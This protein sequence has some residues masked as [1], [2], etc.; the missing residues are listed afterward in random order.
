MNIGVS[1]S[2][3][4]RSG[5]IWGRRKESGPDC[6]AKKLEDH[7]KGGH[8]NG[9]GAGAPARFYARPCESGGS[10]DAVLRKLRKQLVAGLRPL[11]VLL[12]HLLDEL[13]HVVVARRVLQELVV[14]LRALQS[15]VLDRDEVVNKVAGAGAG[16]GST[17][18]L[19]AECVHQWFFP[20]RGWE[21]S[22][23]RQKGVSRQLP[24][25][26]ERNLA[27]PPG[28]PTAGLAGRR[29]PCA[30]R[31]RAPAFARPRRAGRVRHAPRPARLGRGG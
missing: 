5:E 25:S 20:R 9:P 18:S 11:R 3:T 16:H 24:W 21:D 8:G 15:V 6:S 14:D 23:M 12:L 19:G 17:P 30:G 1:W 27:R 2:Q 13:L 26:R 28:R 31:R 22:R 7:S 10:A 4:L 29:R